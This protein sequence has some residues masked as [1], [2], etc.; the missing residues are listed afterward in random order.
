MEYKHKL[1]TTDKNEKESYNSAN[2]NKPKVSLIAPV[3]NESK[4]LKEFYTKVREVIKNTPNFQWEIVFIDDGSTDSSWDVIK[5]LA[6]QDNLVKV[7]ALR[8][9]RNFGKEIALTAGVEC[10]NSDAVICIDADLQHPPELIPVLL[11]KWQEGF[12]IVITIRK[13]AADYSL[14]KKIG[15]KFFYYLM[16]RFSDLKIPPGSTDYRL[17]DKKVVQVLKTFKERTRLFRGL[18]DWMG[19]R[20][21]YVVFTAPARADGNSSFNYKKLFDLAINSFTSFSLLPLRFTGYLGILITL[22]SLGLLVFMVITKFFFNM[23][24]TPLAFFTVFNTLLIGIVLCALGFIALYI[25]HIH[26]EVVRR[27]L[28]IVKEEIGFK[29]RGS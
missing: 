12:D 11:K 20:K 28:Y 27:P 7:K 5:T 6:S 19:F 21:A 23:I 10:V 9:S 25:G 4:T 13:S 18:I 24:Y 1:P 8:F 29:K 2:V 14:L 15:S 17:L 26:T 3:Y 16:N 22:S